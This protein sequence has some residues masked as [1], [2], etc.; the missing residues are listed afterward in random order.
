[1]RHPLFAVAADIAR[2]VL[3]FS[4]AFLFLVISAVY[5]SAIAAL[6]SH[7]IA[8]RFVFHVLVVL[9]YAIVLSDAALVLM[10]LAGNLRDS[11]KR[12]IK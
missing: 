12:I 6:A 8:S 9:E 10:Y 3:L 2:H 7:A 11:F 4:T 1:M 5:G